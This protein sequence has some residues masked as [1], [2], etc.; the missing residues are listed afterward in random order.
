ME[1]IRKIDRRGRTLYYKVENGRQVRVAQSQIPP[2]IVDSIPLH[3]TQSQMRAGQTHTDQIR[4]TYPRIRLRFDGFMIDELILLDD[5][6]FIGRDLVAIIEAIG[7]V[8]VREREDP[9]QTLIDKE[10]FD[11]A[12][13][14]LKITKTKSRTDEDFCLYCQDSHENMISLPCSHCLCLQGYKFCQTHGM[15]C[16][17]CKSPFIWEESHLLL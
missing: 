3:Q 8:E 17:V 11:E 10:S 12:I 2:E 7:N 6:R 5:D 15:K 1:Y 13:A 9:I 16:F 4:E 14:A